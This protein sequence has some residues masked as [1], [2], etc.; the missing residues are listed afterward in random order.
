[1]KTDKILTSAEKIEY[2]LQHFDF[3]EVHKIMTLR[4]HRWYSNTT[5]GLEIPSR[6]EIIKTA[7]NLL[8]LVNK[9]G[10]LVQTG[11]LTAIKQESED[12]YT[13]FLLFYGVCSTT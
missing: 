11:G 8:E 7:R 3:E 5:G 9:Q 4:Q 2:I 1:M 6:S 13:Q 10:G 12:G